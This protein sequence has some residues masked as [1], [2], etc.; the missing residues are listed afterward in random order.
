ML[1][2]PAKIEAVQSWLVP[3]SLKGIQQF[4]SLADYYNRFVY[5]F[6]KLATPLTAL[7]AKNTPLHFRKR[8]F[9]AFQS[10]K[11]ALC[12]PLCLALSCLDLPFSMKCD[13]NDVAI[14]G[15]LS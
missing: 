6:A 14:G 1:V 2:N 11:K 12:N 10:L 13:A 4:P 7:L 8:K 15:I 9:C 3:I 5:N